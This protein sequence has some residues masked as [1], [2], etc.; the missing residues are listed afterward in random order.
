MPSVFDRI[1]VIFKSKL[2]S[3]TNILRDS[4]M[5]I[6]GALP[7]SS[8]NTKK[9][10]DDL[11]VY[12]FIP[13]NNYQILEKIDT[14]KIRNLD[15]HL[16][17][18]INS[19]C[20]Y[21]FDVTLEKYITHAY[22]MPP[23]IFPK[24]LKEPK[25]YPLIF[26]EKNVFEIGLTKGNKYCILEGHQN[27]PSCLVID[28]NA[29]SCY[30]K[31]AIELQNELTLIYD[32]FKIMSYSVTDT[33]PNNPNWKFVL[34]KDVN[35]QIFII[36]LTKNGPKIISLVLCMAGIIKNALK[37][38]ESETGIVPDGLIEIG[39]PDYDEHTKKIIREAGKKLKLEIQ[40]YDNM[41]Y[42]D[43]ELVKFEDL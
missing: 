19:S 24:L 7:S 37:I 40:L 33:L 17:L 4:V 31:N 35:N 25:K 11:I 5:F 13:P 14:S 36:F 2:E 21:K 6:D 18:E 43:M 9:L 15:A 16:F 29:K 20:F 38:I 26:F 3:S 30:G 42:R 1:G 10:V 27:I 8:S 39:F 12:K 28:E 32:L 41:G 34:T 22:S 23:K